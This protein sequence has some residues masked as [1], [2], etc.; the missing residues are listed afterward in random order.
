MSSSTF[1]FRSEKPRSLSWSPDASIFAVAVGPHV[2]V[3]DPIA[4]CLR[5]TL[6]SP[7]CQATEHAHFIGATGRH[8]VAAG[9]KAITLWDLIKSQG[10][11]CHIQNSTWLTFLVLWQTTT[12]FEIDR[13]I[14]HPREDSFAV[15]HCSTVHQDRHTK[16]SIFR[17]PS[18]ISATKFLVPFGLQNV[19]WNS[20]EKGAGYNLVGITHD[21]RVVV[22]GDTQLPPRDDN[23]PTKGLD[24]A[25]RSEKRTLFEDIFGTSAFA[26]GNSESLQSTSTMSS[27]VR[28]PEGSRHELFD[29]PAYLMPALDTLFDPLVTSLL[30]IRNPEVDPKISGA[31]DDEDEDVTM[32]DDTVQQPLLATRP[33]RIPNQGEMELFT[34]LFR[35]TSI[36]STYT[37]FF[38]LRYIL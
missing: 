16:V 24:I 14:A 23:L 31:D 1:A 36:T 28:K 32:I 4:G 7:E 25:D 33:T 13:I 22:L 5:Q 34:Q 35:K 2:A 27:H 3:Y 30:R 9:A 8:L 37:H 12:S 29:R 20:I 17:V 6:T 19:I 15:F 21:W 10:M 26:K 11:F 18:Y 38:N